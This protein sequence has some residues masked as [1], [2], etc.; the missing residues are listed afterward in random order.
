[1]NQA[2]GLDH[3]G[4]VGPDL[5][6]LAAAFDAVGFYLTPLA[7]HAGG[8]TGNRCAIFAEG[9][10]LELMSTIDGG[11]S[12]TLEKFLAR[13][14]GAHTL[15]FRPIQMR[16]QQVHACPFTQ[17]HHVT[18]CKDTW[19]EL[20]IDCFR[21]DIR[22]RLRLRNPESEC[23]ANTGLQCWFHAVTSA[24]N[25]DSARHIESCGGP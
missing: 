23:V 6:T 15:F 19:H 25:G 13:H 11:T 21:I 5:P 24:G 22:N 8:R 12:A 10:Y 17:C 14:V 1:M 20:E 9:G 18:G 16:F 2:T 7:R 3:V 4:I